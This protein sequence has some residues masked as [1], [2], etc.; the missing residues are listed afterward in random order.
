[1]N[2]YK[3]EKSEETV[4]GSLNSNNCI[5]IYVYSKFQSNHDSESGTSLMLLS[6]KNIE[7]MR[8]MLEN[9]HPSDYVIYVDHPNRVEY[10]DSG[11]DELQISISFGD[12][13]DTDVTFTKKDLNK[14]ITMFNRG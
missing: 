4:K 6:K 2:D 9:D 1:M 8:E 5:V 14:M 3:L 13:D 11:K 7:D 12:C 10:S